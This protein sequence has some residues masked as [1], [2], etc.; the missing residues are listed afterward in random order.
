MGFG[1]LRHKYSSGISC[2]GKRIGFG[3]LGDK[4]C[5]ILKGFGLTV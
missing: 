5:E 1:F 4:T 2:I 3:F